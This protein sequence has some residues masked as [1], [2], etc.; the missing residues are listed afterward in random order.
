MCDRKQH[1]EHKR[2]FAN[3][4][5]KSYLQ[6]SEDFQ[7]ITR[8]LL[9]N[10][11][12]PIFRNAATNEEPIEL[13]EL[14]AT[15]GMDFTCAYLFGL[16][17]GTDFLGDVKTRQYWLDSY[18]KTKDYITWI[19]ELIVPVIILKA[20]GI[21]LVPASVFQTVDDMGA[22]NL[23][24]C[25]A[26][27]EAGAAG[28]MAGKTRAVIYEQMAQGL[29][30]TEEQEKLAH[31]KNMI[32]ASEMLDQTLAGHELIAITLAYLVYE[33]SKPSNEKVQD[34]LREELRS[35]VLNSQLNSAGTIDFRKSSTLDNLPL[36]DA[37]LKETLRRYP[38]SAGPA[39]RVTPAAGTTILDYKLPGG[40]RISCNQYSLHR[41]GTVFADPES[42]KPQRWLEA[43]PRELQAMKKWFWA[44]GSGS[45]MCLGVHF[46][47][48]GTPVSIPTAQRVI[49]LFWLSRI[50]SDLCCF[51]AEIKVVVAAIYSSYRTRLADYQNYE[52]DMVPKDGFIG[53]P[54]GNRCL[55]QFAALDA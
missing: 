28:K 36:L 48:I 5:T 49:G 45:R 9:L 38:P 17:A 53:R 31:P 13:L 19:A 21:N 33:L 27:E 4:Y 42:W 14:G 55:I 20:V 43:S 37:V 22:W 35:Y 51:L 8:E 46:V 25:K 54:R 11:I 40:V 16:D 6:G 39:P 52:D 18:E 10:K 26:V 44:F 15:I 29:G 30:K 7:T 3:V 50:Y 2:L 47:T 34:D 23:K 41:N 12:M 24:M 32:I 1:H